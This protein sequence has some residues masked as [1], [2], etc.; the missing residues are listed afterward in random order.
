MLSLKK[1]TLHLLISK[2]CLNDFTVL[3]TVVDFLEVWD[4]FKHQ[5]LQAAKESIRKHMR[6]RSGIASGETLD[7]IDKNHSGMVAD[8]QENQDQLQLSCCFIP[9][10]LTNI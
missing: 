4:T 5:I 3:D 9:K 8:N 6:S 10:K 7:N 1:Q 2:Q